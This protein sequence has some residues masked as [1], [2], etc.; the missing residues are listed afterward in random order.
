MRNSRC[1]SKLQFGDASKLSVQGITFRKELVV[2]ATMSGMMFFCWASSWVCSVF[3]TSKVTKNPAAR[4]PLRHLRPPV[5]FFPTKDVLKE[6][7]PRRLAQAWLPPPCALL[8]LHQHV[9]ECS[10]SFP[11]LPWPRQGEPLLSSLPSHSRREWDPRSGL[12]N[13]PLSVFLS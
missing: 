5:F 8:S 2:S 6:G 11:P 10:A 12:P 1:P 7:D 13:V 9:L 4:S 3:P